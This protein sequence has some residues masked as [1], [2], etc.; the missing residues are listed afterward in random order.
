M[1]LHVRVRRTYDAAQ[2]RGGV[3]TMRLSTV[4]GTAALLTCL[5]AGCAFNEGP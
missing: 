3:S 2:T 4:R 1:R 5:G